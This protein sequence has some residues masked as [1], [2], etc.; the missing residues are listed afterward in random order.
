MS[1]PSQQNLPWESLYWLT[2]LAR[3]Q[4]FTQA[5][6]RLDV[7]KAAVSQKI[8]A[9]ELQVGVQLVHRTTRSVRLTEAGH[10]LVQELEQPFTLIA[11]SFQQVLDSSGPIRGLV[12]MTAPVA[13]ARQH[14]VPALTDFLNSYPQIRV[15]LEV[16]DRLIS[17]TKEG[18]DLAVRHS[19]S[20]PDNYVAHPL[21]QTRTLLV[22]SPNYLSHSAGLN[23]PQDLNQHNCLYYPRGTK[24]P[25]WRFQHRQHTD[26][27][28]EVQ[29]QA[30][31][32][33][34]NSESIRDGA[35]NGLGV[36]ML[37]DFSAQAA[38]SSGEL[39]EVLPDWQC[40]EE[41][42][43]QIWVIRPYQRNVPRAVA[44]LS[45]WLRNRFNHELNRL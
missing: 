26:D 45:R 40:L 19:D 5:A 7:S 3:Q 34:N 8:K 10:A 12:R 18:Y 29:I 17:L 23:H 2:I 32:A 36:A 30:R 42:A 6:E 37:P 21:C 38:L 20:L 28:T 35:L 15:Q 11:Q 22:A 43:Q 1:Q 41:F 4:S 44:L 27:L 16:S 9:L 24:L 25:I 14:L 33:T 31:F 39:V 13:F